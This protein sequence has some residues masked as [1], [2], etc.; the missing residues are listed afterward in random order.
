MPFFS[1]G[2]PTQMSATSAPSS[3]SL[4]ETEAVKRPAVDGVADQGFEPG[5]EEGRAAGADG[6]DL[7]LVAVHADDAMAEVRQAGG[8]DTS[9]IAQA[10]DG[11]LLGIHFTRNR[12]HA[13]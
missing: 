3:A 2:V 7:E 5:F 1:D 4:R 8:G 9:D 10:Q 6:I 11:N 12:I 13:L